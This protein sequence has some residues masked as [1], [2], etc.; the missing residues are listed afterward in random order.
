M[1]QYC[2]VWISA[3]V[4]APQLSK[5]CNNTFIQPRLYCDLEFSEID[6]WL[7]FV[8]SRKHLSRPL[9]EHSLSL[10]PTL[11]HTHTQS[12][13]NGTYPFV[14]T[15]RVYLNIQRNLFQYN[16]RK[17]GTVKIT[18]HCHHQRIVTHFL[19]RV[20]LWRPHFVGKTFEIL[21]A[22]ILF[23]VKAHVYLHMRPV[24][25]VYFSEYH[26]QQSAGK[27]QTVS[28]LGHVFEKS[29][30]DYR[31]L[32]AILFHKDPD[33]LWVPPPLIQWVSGSQLPG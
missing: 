23:K 26:I 7:K 22:Y 9:I 20:P 13:F 29:W 28:W 4:V 33:R 17:W 32:Q 31:K 11:T 21:R 14:A 19:S 1:V 8:P 16:Q 24:C 12:T 27:T 6:K 3:Y 30:F 5:T 25:V 18:T 2:V 15:A 10:P